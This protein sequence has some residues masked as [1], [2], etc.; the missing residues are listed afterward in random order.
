[1]CVCFNGYYHH[2]HHHHHQYS[3]SGIELSVRGSAHGLGE[4]DVFTEASLY[5]SFLFV[6]VCILMSVCERVHL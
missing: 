2:H 3:C 6:I 5:C 4:G 1:M